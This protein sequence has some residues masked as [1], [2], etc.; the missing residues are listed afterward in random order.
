[1]LSR[2]VQTLIFVHSVLFLALLKEYD[3][4]THHCYHVIGTSTKFAFPKTTLTTCPPDVMTVRANSKDLVTSSSV[5]HQIYQ[6][7]ISSTSCQ[8]TFVIHKRSTDNEIDFNSEISVLVSSLSFS[9]ISAIFR[10]DTPGSSVADSSEAVS[11]PDVAGAFPL[12]VEIVESDSQTLPPGNGYDPSLF[13]PILDRFTSPVQTFVIV[14]TGINLKIDYE[15]LNRVDTP[16]YFTDLTFTLFPITALGDKA[17]TP[18]ATV[19]LGGWTTSR[20]DCPGFSNFELVVPA[21]PHPMFVEATFNNAATGSTE[22]S[23]YR[24]TQSGH[25]LEDGS[26]FMIHNLSFELF[27]STG[28]YV[29]QSSKIVLLP[30]DLATKKCVSRKGEVMDVSRNTYRSVVVHQKGTLSTAL[31][32]TSKGRA[33]LPISPSEGDSCFARS[34]FLLG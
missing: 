17:T 4:Q 29:G 1:M 19:S 3:P 23:T 8:S 22:K 25:S 21:Y 34:G 9:R 24:V 31:D 16:R 6:L 14:E 33:S 7:Q 12:K 30:S 26:Q 32:G 28:S 27:S 18:L 20:A 2:S 13:R 5:D 15:S 11:L 10:T